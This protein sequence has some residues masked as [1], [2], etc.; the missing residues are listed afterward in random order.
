MWIILEGLDRSGKTSV[1]KKYKKMGYEVYHMNAPD[2]KYLAPG[3]TGPSYADEMVEVYMQYDGKNVLFDRS[4]YGEVVWPAVFGRDPRL[5]DNDIEMLRE[6]EQTN[7]AEYILMYDSKVEDHWRRCVENNE[8]LN[9]GQFNHA[10]VAYNQM[11]AKYSFKKK[12]L[13]EF[14][15]IKVTEKK[16]TPDLNKENHEDAAKQSAAVKKTVGQ[17][18]LDKAN[19]INQVLN[20]RII[21]RKGK[22]FDLLEQDIRNFLEDKL[23]TLFGVPSKDFTEE[24]KSVLKLFCK[25]MLNK[26]EEKK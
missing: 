7:D 10:T 11:A 13:E 12:Q 16:T 26:A 18:K 22:I 15:D 20:S 19:A 17:I 9:R 14:Q 2:K 24:E 4:I 8:P 21:K 5:T 25:Q 1:A 23:G 6:F 3:Y